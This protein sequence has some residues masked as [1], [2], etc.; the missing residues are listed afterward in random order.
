MGDSETS[1]EITPMKTHSQPRIVRGLVANVRKDRK[2]KH[3]L[4][5]RSDTPCHSES[6]SVITLL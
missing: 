3:K 1:G 5:R 4:F 6:T 2:H